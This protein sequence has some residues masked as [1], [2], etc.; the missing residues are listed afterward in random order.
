V[1]HC[2]L[3][4]LGV[5]G[6]NGV[7]ALQAGGQGREPRI[8]LTAELAIVNADLTRLEQIITNL[9][10]NAVKYTPAGGS[11]SIDVATDAREAI[12]RVT[13]TGRGIPAEMLS[14]V[15]ELFAQ[16][17]QPID[18]SLGGLGV[19]LTLT[20]RL[21]ELHG[22]TIPAFSEGE[23]R[24]AQFTVR[25]PLDVT[26]APFGPPFEPLPRGRPRRIL[27][28]EDSQDARETLRLLLEDQ[29]HQ[30]TE[31]TDGTRGVAVALAGQPEAV[32]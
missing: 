13:D 26:A 25:L 16:V 22:G 1:L 20:R 17:E 2:E 8:P 10:Q 15:F 29:G 27:I 6:G 7:R 28:I 24:G 5:V 32:P 14:Q 19:G 9:L 4:D 12:L 30:V 11:I 23:G 31:A 3:V 21:V 18:R